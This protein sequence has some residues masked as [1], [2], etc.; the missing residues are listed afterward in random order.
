MASD[1]WLVASSTLLA[2]DQLAKFEIRDFKK[3]GWQR[4]LLSAL[5]PEHDWHWSLATDH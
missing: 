2:A 3:K 1:Q 4:V 5:Q